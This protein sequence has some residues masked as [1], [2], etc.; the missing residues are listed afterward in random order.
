LVLETAIE[1]AANKFAAIFVV[2]TG[3]VPVVTEELAVELTELLALVEAVE[4]A[5]EAA[6]AVVEETAEG[7]L[8]VVAG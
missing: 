2:L 8:W 1:G 3:A 4:A 5:E 7:A 6:G